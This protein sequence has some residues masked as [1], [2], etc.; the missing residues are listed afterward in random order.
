MNRR[1][2]LRWTAGAAAAAGTAIEAQQQNPAAS[3]AAPAPPAKPLWKPVVFDAHQFATVSVLCDQIVPAT[4]TPGALAAGVPRYL[5]LM[6][7]H[8]RPSQREELLAGLAWIDAQAIRQQ[9]VPLAKLP[10]ASQAALLTALDDATA[11]ASARYFRQWKS[12]IAQIYYNTAAGYR[13]L[14][15]GGRVPSGFGCRHGQHG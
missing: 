5:D 2:W 13:E 4:D 8:S 11:G 15:K 9:G 3:G 10:P 7:S 6:L 14:N 1:N 12:A